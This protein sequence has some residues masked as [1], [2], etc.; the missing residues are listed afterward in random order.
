MNKD[1]NE[2]ITTTIIDK[3]AKY[4]NKPPNESLAKTIIS[5]ATAKSSEDFSKFTQIIGLKNE[6]HISDVYNSVKAANNNK[7]T[8]VSYKLRTNDNLKP[9]QKRP[10]VTLSYE[11]TENDEEE[12]EDVNEDETVMPNVKIRPRDESAKSKQM[13]FKKMRK[14]DA[15][16]M[17]QVSPEIQSHHSTKTQPHI[18]RRN[19]IEFKKGG[20]KP[21]KTNV[22]SDVGRNTK[23]VN[24]ESQQESNV[25]TGGYFNEKGDYVDNDHAKSNDFSR[26]PIVSHVFIPPFLTKSKDYLTLQITG[27]SVKG[28]GPTINPIKNINSELASMAKQGSLVVQSKKSTKEK[29]KQA[30]SKVGVD[31]KEVVSE[32][33]KDKEPDEKYDYDSIQKQRQSLPAYAVR[34]EVVSAIKENQVTIVIG[35]TGSGKT[36]QLAQFLYEQGL[37]NEGKIIGCTQ[38]RRVAAMSVAKRVSEEMDVKLGEEVGY[39]VRF[40]D[41]TVKS[42]TVIKYMTEGILLREFLADPSLNDYSC[43]IMDEAHERALNTDILLGLFKSLLARRK[44]LKLIVTSATMNADRFTRFFGAAPQFT[45]P[46]RTFPVD[47]YFN[48]NVSMDYVETAVKQVISIHLQRSAENTTKFINDGDILVFMTGQED[49][50]ITCDMIRE[51]LEMLENPPPLDI[52]PIYSSMPQELQ[53]KIFNR[54]NPNKR[55]VVVATN[56]AETSLTVDGIKYVIDCGL[57][58]VKVYNPKLGMD[59]LQVVPISVANADQ[60]SGRAGRTNAGVAYRL[61]TERAVDPQNMYEQP[62][63]EIQRTNLS[64][65][66]LLLKSLKINDINNFPFLDPPPKDLLNCS[67]YDLWAIG[68]I[69]NLGE[70]TKLGLDMIQFPIEPT[71]AKLILLSCKDEFHCSEEIL[72]IVGMLSVPNIFQRSKERGSEADK[73]REKFIINDSDHLTLLNIYNQWETHSN[74]VGNSYSK[75]NLWCESNFLQMRSLVRAKEVKRQLTTIMAKRKLPILRSYNDEDIK[76]CLC[77]SF[78]QQSALLVKNHINGTPEFQNLRHSYMKMYLHPTSGLNNSNLSSNFVIYHELVLTSKEYMNYVTCVDPMWLLQY[79]FKFFGVPLESMDK[80]IG[81]K[82]FTTKEDF[83]KELEQDRLR[84]EDIEAKSLKDKGKDLPSSSGKKS[85]LFKRRTAF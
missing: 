16:Q 66:M 52:I 65:T 9:K 72:T 58:K 48:K 44:D 23:N 32:E 5:Q 69:D 50:E 17:K 7:P 81:L 77:A 45:I 36:T 11:E 12:E 29:A 3:L 55:K 57:V 85:L 82:N 2:H 61:Y 24:S 67:L 19:Q 14:E 78:Y 60:R 71:L 25:G 74:K 38:P 35:E 70:L 34:N 84:F 22:P 37:T 39:S 76:K 4:L 47:V 64:N 18:E 42:K 8:Q 49:I 56:I 43:I 13:S 27:T 63:P 33:V 79:G 6:D 30:K 73:A 53:K 1:E 80:L 62:I 75:L 20:H 46:G 28:V 31:T 59:T 21:M 10:G 51:K 54:S 41:K 83:E 26:I 68:A 15:A 40:D